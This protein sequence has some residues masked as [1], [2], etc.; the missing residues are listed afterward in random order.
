MRNT[1]LFALVAAML[2]CTLFA[3][4]ALAQRDRVFVASYGSDSNP[5]TFGSPCK[6]FQQAI[7]VVAAGGEVTAIDSAGF[8]PIAISHAITITSPNGVEAGIAVAAGTTGITINAGPSDVVSLHGLTL[9]GAGAGQSGIIFNAGARLEIIDSVVQN[10]AD[11]GIFVDP[12]ANM[13]LLISNTRVLDNPNSAGIEIA[14]QTS[15]VVLASIDHVTIENN[16]YGIYLDGSAHD[17]II[18]AV[19][20]NSIVSSNANTGVAV[21]IS[22]PINFGSLATIK[23]TTLSHNVSNGVSTSGSGSEILLSHVMIEGSHTGINIGSGTIISSAG[24]N[25][26]FDTATPVSG[27]LS[28]APEQ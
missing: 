18:E 1:S 28:A 4:P 2:A 19:I 24:N 9:E 15:S 12:A 26:I 14:P 10:F 22:N 11:T 17:A 3:A 5:C 20:T 7:N 13:T 27:T 16:N 23:D 25:D 21:F 6:T 8:G